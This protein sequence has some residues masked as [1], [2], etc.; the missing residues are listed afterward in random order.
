MWKEEISSVNTPKQRSHHVALYRWHNQRIRAH[1]SGSHIYTE[2]SQR[3]LWFIEQYQ[4]V[5]KE[6]LEFRSS[7][8]ARSHSFTWHFN[9]IAWFSAVCIMYEWMRESGGERTELCIINV[10]NFFSSSS[11]IK[12]SD[13]TRDSLMVS[14]IVSCAS[15]RLVDTINIARQ[16]NNRARYRMKEVLAVLTKVRKSDHNYKELLAS[17]W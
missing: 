4:R 7:L 15:W 9:R 2:Q 14:D 3:Y 11:A 17:Q 10:A 12:H 16:T 13:W 8:R 6:K 1:F 5:N